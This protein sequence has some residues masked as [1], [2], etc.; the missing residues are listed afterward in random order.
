M[1]NLKRIWET[2]IESTVKFLT[3]EAIKWIFS[4]A[5]AYFTVL[6]V[7]VNLTDI[8]ADIIDLVFIFL[9]ILTIF[10]HFV[11]YRRIKKENKSLEESLEVSTISRFSSDVEEGYKL[12]RNACE[13][14]TLDP[15]HP[16]NPA[17][18][19]AYARDFVNPLSGKLRKAGF[20][21]PGLCTVEEDSLREWFGFLEDVRI[22]LKEE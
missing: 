18:I 14:E 21:P 2:I 15:A 19:K 9:F 6:H 10:A 12:L 17:A 7:K 11:A 5:F 20:S 1:G 13:P 4:V 22:R 3:R 16:G 8:I